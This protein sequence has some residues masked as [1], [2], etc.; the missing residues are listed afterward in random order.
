[1]KND[2]TQKGVS[3]EGEGEKDKLSETEQREIEK[4]GREL[5]ASTRLTALDAIAAN[6]DR[7]RVEED[8]MVLDPGSTEE[9]RTTDMPGKGTIKTGPDETTDNL[10]A[11]EQAEIERIKVD[12][13]EIEVPRT[14]VIEAGIRTLQKE[15]AAD[16]RLEEATNLKRSAEQLLADAKKKAQ[17]PAGAETE[18]VGKSA[19]TPEE[20]TAKKKEWVQAI[21]YGEEAEA[22][23]ALDEMMDFMGRGSTPATSRDEVSQIVE[24]TI[25]KREQAQIDSEMAN[26]RQKFGSSRDQGGFDD[27]ASSP[28]LMDEVVK[29]VNEKLEK[30]S[31]NVWETYEEAGNEIRQRREEALKSKGKTEVADLSEKRKKKASIDNVSSVS[32]TSASIRAAE[33][34]KT[35]EEYRAETVKEIMKSRGQMT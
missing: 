10:S 12:G 17:Q 25:R 18:T 27:L 34:T 32:A 31:P 35:E 6:V 5:A 26:I 8:G 20:L 7:E 21:Q 29:I 1:M 16:Q 2:A 9:T 11:E 33:E 4:S 13:K 23:K 14:K 19:L 3:G 24:E 28:Y 30:G 22:A 15:T